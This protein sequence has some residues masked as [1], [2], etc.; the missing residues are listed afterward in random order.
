[1][2]KDRSIEGV[3]A[4]AIY[5]ACRE[6]GV[7]GTLDEISEAAGIERKEIGRA[8]RAVTRG[9]GINLQHESH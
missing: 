8:F 9:H 6:C 3:T 7:P 1:M 5:L 4:A 2:I